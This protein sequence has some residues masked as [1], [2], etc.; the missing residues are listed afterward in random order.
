MFEELTHKLDLAVRKLRGMGKL[1]EKNMT[2]SMRD[3]RRVLLEADV[4]YKVV[5]AFIARVQEKALGKEILQSITPGQQVVKIVHDELVN[6]LGRANVPIKF[7]S[8]PPSVV[9][10]V[11][12]QGSGKTTFVGKLGVYLRKKGRNTILVAADVHRPA[13][14]EQLETLGRSVNLPVFSMGTENPVRIVKEAV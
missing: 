7:G 5:K 11:G 3:I 6:L 14:V 9:M 13:A 2:E 1:T 10:V 8:V 4:H 12:L